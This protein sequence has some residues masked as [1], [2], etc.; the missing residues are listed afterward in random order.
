[1]RRTARSI[2]DGV[3]V[4]SALPRA[5][6]L[7]EVPTE[8]L[9]LAV[10]AAGLEVWGAHQ[11]GSPVYRFGELLAAATEAGLPIAEQERRRWVRWRRRSDAYGKEQ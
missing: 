9:A 5:A 1:M 6:G 3:P 11:D 7:L 4:V 2:P 8:D 10:K